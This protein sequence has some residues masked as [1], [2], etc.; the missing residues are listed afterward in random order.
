MCAQF[1][2][3][4]D[5]NHEVHWRILYFGLPMN[6][7]LFHSSV[8]NNTNNT[9]YCYYCQND[10]D[11]RIIHEDNDDDRRNQEEWNPEWNAER[12]E[13]ENKNKQMTAKICF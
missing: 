6:S 11:R 10:N 8:C 7:I 12:K 5:N 13:R 9:Y 3:Q 2:A 4:N 1:G